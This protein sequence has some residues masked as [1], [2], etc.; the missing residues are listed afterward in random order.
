M[1]APMQR[2]GEGDPHPAY[3]KGSKAAMI[4]GTV[5]SHCFL[6]SLCMRLQIPMVLRKRL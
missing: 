4:S 3:G 1:S 5:N 2:A 6:L